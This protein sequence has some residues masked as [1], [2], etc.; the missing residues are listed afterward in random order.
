M[1][2]CLALG[3]LAVA[4]STFDVGT[5]TFEAYHKPLLGLITSGIWFSMNV[6]ESQPMKR[7]HGELPIIK[8]TLRLNALSAFEL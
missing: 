1:C 6:Y 4:L 3:R 2:V 7:I 5:A 8:E